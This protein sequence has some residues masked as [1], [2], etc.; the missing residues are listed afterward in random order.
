MS[1]VK[2]QLSAE[3]QEMVAN[4]GIIL[5]KNRILSTIMEL[6]G[7][8]SNAEVQYL[9]KHRNRLP[10]EVFSFAPKIARG[11]NY[12][13]LPWLMLDYPRVFQP[14][15]SLAVRHFFWWGNFFSVGIQV[16]G[17]FKQQLAKAVSHWPAGSYICVHASPWEHH[18]GPDNYQPV[19]RL[20]SAT[21]KDI[22][23]KSDFLKLAMVI[24][25]SQWEAV[26]AFL[27]NGFT[28]YLELLMD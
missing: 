1:G 12:Q 21:I 4:S 5:T 10:A 2:I 8:V 16:S 27:L 18:F 28:S 14:E 19:A 25:V 26:P 13:Q 22:L 6:F 11:E 20:S 15:A 9:E 7:V 23:E 17:R 3:E 24:P